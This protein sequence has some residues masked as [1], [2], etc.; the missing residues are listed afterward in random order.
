MKGIKMALRGKGS[1][2]LPKCQTSRRKA[3]QCSSGA[4]QEPGKEERSAYER[5]FAAI[6]M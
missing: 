6:S 1:P 5:A 2:L 4:P 3:H